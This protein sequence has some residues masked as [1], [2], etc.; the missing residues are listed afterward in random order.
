MPEKI[1]DIRGRK[2]GGETP[3]ICT[4]LVGRTRER[5]LAET[6]SVLEKRPDVID[7]PP[8]LVGDAVDVTRQLGCRVDQ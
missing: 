8:R 7:Q 2:L 5:V 6:A 3:L 1:I 4:P